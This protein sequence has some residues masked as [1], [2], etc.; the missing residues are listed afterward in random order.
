MSRY[1]IY[2]DLRFSDIKNKITKQME[3]KYIDFQ[4]TPYALSDVCETLYNNGIMNAVITKEDGR[5]HIRWK[6]DINRD[7]P[8]KTSEVGENVMETI[9]KES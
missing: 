2:D 7:A 9:T 3:E 8:K 4:V 1:S 5:I 6:Y